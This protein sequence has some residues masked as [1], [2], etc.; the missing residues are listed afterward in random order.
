MGMRRTVSFKGTDGIRSMNHH[1]PGELQG[2]CDKRLMLF[3]L[4][5]NYLHLFHTV[6]TTILKGNTDMSKA[7]KAGMIE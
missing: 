4:G 2:H 5:A 3:G 1:P 6:S 7:I